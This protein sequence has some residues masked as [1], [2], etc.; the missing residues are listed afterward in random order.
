MANILSTV[1]M[2]VLLNGMPEPWIPCRHGLR[3]GDPLSPYLFTVVANL[4]H[5]MVTDVAAPMVL[6]HPLVDDLECPMIQYTDDTLVL[7]RAE[8]AQVRRLK[9][10]LDDF[11]ATTGLGSTSPRVPSSPSMSTT[12]MPPRWRPSSAAPWGGG[13][14]A[15]WDSPL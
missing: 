8:D 9:V 7:L 11:A 1:R 13:P 15:I 4:L 12:S 5:R 3:Q 14:R 10:V 6:R 2:A